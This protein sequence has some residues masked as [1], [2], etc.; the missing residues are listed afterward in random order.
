MPFAMKSCIDFDKLEKAVV[1]EEV[2]FMGE[3][4]DLA[5]EE[6]KKLTANWGHDPKFEKKVIKT[7]SGKIKVEV[8]VKGDQKTRDIFGWV[9][10]GTGEKAGGEAYVIPKEKGKILAFSSLYTPKTTPKSHG[11]PGKSS[12]PIRFATKVRHT[13]IE[14]RNFTDRVREAVMKEME[15]E[16][17]KRI[18]AVV[19]KTAPSMSNF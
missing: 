15:G 10:K 12:G 1:A 13:G 7:T 16:L 5:C 4:G 2:A 17:P 19:A 11:G 6:F 9:N 8:W 18:K 3:I 14:P